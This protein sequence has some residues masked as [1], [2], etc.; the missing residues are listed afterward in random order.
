MTK[1]EAGLLF[2]L[3]KLAFELQVERKFNMSNESLME[4]MPLWEELAAK[5]D[6]LN[7]ISKNVGAFDI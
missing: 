1:R 5:I 6:T 3:I 7:G 2:G 4:I